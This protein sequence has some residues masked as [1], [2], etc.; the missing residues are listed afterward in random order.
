MLPFPVHAFKTLQK[1]FSSAIIRVQC[2]NFL[3]LFYFSTPW[4]FHL[5][6][7]H[8]TAY[9]ANVCRRLKYFVHTL[10]Y[11]AY[12]QHKFCITY[13]YAT[14]RWHTLSYV[15]YAQKILCVHKISN[16]CRRTDNTVLL[17]YAYATNTLCTNS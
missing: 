13:G 6:G 3:C 17:S 14:I 11:V 8:T 12:V 15:V 10:V 4:A 7:A 2:N 5:R 9:S 16:V 1:V